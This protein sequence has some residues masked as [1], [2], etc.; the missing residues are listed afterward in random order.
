MK[1]ISG[2]SLKGCHGNQKVVSP[3]LNYITIYDLSYW[4]VQMSKYLSNI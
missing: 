4:E 2:S 3:S 1:T